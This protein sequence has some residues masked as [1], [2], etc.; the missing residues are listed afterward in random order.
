MSMQE[1]F[2]AGLV[3]A[4]NRRDF[5]SA[6]RLASEGLVHAT[7]R[8]EV[9]WMGLHESCEGYRLLLAGNPDRSE[10]HMMIAMQNLRNFGYNYQGLQVTT[11]L[12]GLRRCVEEF[13]V[14]KAQDKRIFDVTLVPQLR[15]ADEVE[16]SF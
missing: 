4:F 14:V 6:A 9:F 7:G 13:R 2:L 11:L 12:A 5:Q 3:T 1:Q 16:Q 15:L 10:H 8:D